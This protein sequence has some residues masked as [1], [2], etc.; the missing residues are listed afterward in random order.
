VKPG[1]D[2]TVTCPAHGSMFRLADGRVMR[3]PA[4]TPV[5]SYEARVTDGMVELRQA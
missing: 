2:P 1:V 3:P 4:G 5:A